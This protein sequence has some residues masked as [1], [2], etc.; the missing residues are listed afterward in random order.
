MTSTV[1]DMSFRKAPVVPNAVLAM[2]IVLF[3]EAMF[4]CGLLSAHIVL[5]G[6]AGVWPPLDQPRLSVGFTGFNTAIL[7]VSGV[8]IW[9]CRANLRPD[10]LH[11]FSR[12]LWAT[13]VSG[14]LFLFLQG[15]EWVSLIKFG[16][17][18]SSS[19][20][21]SLFYTIIGCHALHVAVGLLVLLVMVRGFNKGTWGLDE[22]GGFLAARMYWI[23]VVAVWPPLYCTVYLW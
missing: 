6:Q 22:H 7:L 19:L 20:Y 11:K 4:F 2:W 16:L 15:V 17:T 23:F 12:M 13:L 10:A 8:L 1:S 18:S 3:A 14:A 9:R 21:G 5:R